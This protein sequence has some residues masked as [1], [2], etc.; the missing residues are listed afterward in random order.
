MSPVPD[1]WDTMRE[2][3]ALLR[4]TQLL[5]MNLQINI[6][7]AFAISPLLVCFAQSKL[8]SDSSD[9]VKDIV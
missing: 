7:A 1:E 5:S 9:L 4:T 8:P 6:L 3:K 2:C